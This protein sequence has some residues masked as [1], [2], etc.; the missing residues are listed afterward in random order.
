MEN[1]VQYYIQ[2]AKDGIEV[3][4]EIIN[5]LSKKESDII[6]KKHGLTTQMF[7]QLNKSV[8]DYYS[9]N[10]AGKK[11]TDF[12]P[13]LEIKAKF[14]DSKYIQD[15]TVRSYLCHVL[16]TSKENIDNFYSANE[17]VKKESIKDLSLNIAIVQLKKIYKIT[18]LKFAKIFKKDETKAITAADI[19]ETKKILET[20]IANDADNII[21]DEVKQLVI[22]KTEIIKPIDLKNIK[23]EIAKTE[24]TVDETAVQNV[25]KYLFA[26]SET[27][28]FLKNMI[29]NLT[30]KDIEKSEKMID[31]LYQEELKKPEAQ[32]IFINKIKDILMTLGHINTFAMKENYENMNV[33]AWAYNV[34]NLKAYH[35][36]ASDFDRIT[37]DV[38]KKVVSVLHRYQPAQ[39][40]SYDAYHLV[41]DFIQICRD[42]I[43]EI[44]ISHDVTDLMLTQILKDYMQKAYDS[45]NSILRI[46]SKMNKT[47][48][49]EVK[50]DE[51]GIVTQ[52][53]NPEKTEKNRRIEV[54]KIIGELSKDVN[55][56]RK[57]F[58]DLYNGMTTFNDKTWNMLDTKTQNQILKGAKL[59][60]NSSEFLDLKLN[61]NITRIT[62]EN[63]LDREAK[64]IAD[65]ESETKKKIE[66]KMSKHAKSFISQFQSNKEDIRLKYKGKTDYMSQI[67]DNYEKTGN[68]NDKVLAIF[69]KDDEF[70]YKLI[71]FARIIPPNGNISSL[72]SNSAT[73]LLNRYIG[74]KD[75]N[76]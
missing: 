36:G 29:P 23:T 11:A 32:R 4:G 52:I 13:E 56:A 20:E 72:L 17:D 40:N 57:F 19:R 49:I 53:V 48:N 44:K 34:L 43:G 35:T 67:I 31:K 2:E 9:K 69:D 15:I 64:M 58:F 26:I 76:R 33:L 28:D 41:E 18:T 59:N 27:F 54:E 51:Q 37:K 5:L 50:K 16:E 25:N 68:I 66:D 1:L 61:R 70:K 63:P 24:I 46:S 73:P 12:I 8:M 55:K 75:E 10:I 42:Q 38:E 7:V 62:G 22:N 60:R 30:I 47:K 21:P 3:D 74:M 39:R 45:V 14:P 6:I 65:L 71:D